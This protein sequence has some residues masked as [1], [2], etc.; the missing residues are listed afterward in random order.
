MTSTQRKQKAPSKEYL[1]KAKDLS[2]ED[3]NQ[4]MLRMRGKFSRRVEDK[5]L[6]VVEALALQLEYEDEQL[7][8]WRSKVAE[9]RNMRQA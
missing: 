9:I 6:A 5:R 1:E 8:A 7:M 4:L 3:A 2:K